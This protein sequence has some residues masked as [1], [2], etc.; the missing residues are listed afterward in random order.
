[1]R[2]VFSDQ[3]ESRRRGEKERRGREERRGGEEGGEKEEV[4][5]EKEGRRGGEEVEGQDRT[6]QSHHRYQP[7]PISSSSSP[8]TRR[9]GGV[10][11]V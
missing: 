10:G 8:M 11:F 6:Y 7:I 9:R 3:L 4:E 2:A 1:M 5:G